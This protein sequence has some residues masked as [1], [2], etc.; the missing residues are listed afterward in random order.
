MRRWPQRSAVHRHTVDRHL[1][2]TVVRAAGLVRRV[3]RPDLLLVAALLH[4]IGKIQGPRLP[5]SPAP[6]RPGRS[7][8]DGG[9]RSEDVDTLVLLVREHLTLIGFATR[10]DHQDP[11]T[12]DAA[13]AAVDGDGDV[14]EILL[15]LSEADASAAGPAAWTD[16]RATLLAQQPVAV[17]ERL[18]GP[19]PG[20]CA[21]RSCRLGDRPLGCARCR[22]VGLG[23]REPRVRVIATG[24]S[25]RLDITDPDRVGLF[26]D[27]AGLLAAEG[28]TVRTAILRTVDGIT[29]STSGTSSRRVERCRMPRASSAGWLASRR[30]IVGP[31]RP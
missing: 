22:W 28:H 4:D 13:I 23:A 25:H 10:R 18:A 5:R 21:R 11:A 20:R 27:T 6:V 12:V 24:G 7:S 1:I 2:E 31:P 8:P 16:W 29:P 26:A 9:S 19:A 14:F 17:R 3:S 15:A 30:G